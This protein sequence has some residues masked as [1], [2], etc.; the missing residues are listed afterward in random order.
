[1]ILSSEAGVLLLPLFITVAKAFIRSP[2]L[3]PEDGKNQ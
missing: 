1:M 2:L 3:S